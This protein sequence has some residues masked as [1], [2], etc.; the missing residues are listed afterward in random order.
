[1]FCRPTCTKP[2]E[3]LARKCPHRPCQAGFLKNLVQTLSAQDYP[4][5]GPK[6]APAS[7]IFHP[8]VAASA[9]SALLPSGLCKVAIWA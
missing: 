4:R 1:M 8:V 3:N 9:R 7:A 6:E 5:R 2:L